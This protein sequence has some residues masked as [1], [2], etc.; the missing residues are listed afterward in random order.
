MFPEQIFKRV[1]AATE[2]KSSIR[3]KSKIYRV[4][5]GRNP[6]IMTIGNRETPTARAADQEHQDQENNSKTKTTEKK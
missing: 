3:H 5:K 4:W 1:Q 6:E 2:T